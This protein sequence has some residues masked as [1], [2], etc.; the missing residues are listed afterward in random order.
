MK[1]KIDVTRWSILVN[2]IALVLLF[3][4]FA[5]VIIDIRTTNNINVRWYEYLL[6][7][8]SYL[9]F[10]FSGFVLEANERYH[11]DMLKEK[12]EKRERKLNA[13]KA[14]RERRDEIIRQFM[15]RERY[16]RNYV[17]PEV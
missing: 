17:V 5:A 6:L 16:R 7:L 1:R 15:Q 12:Y 14:E 9:V 3:I 10:I 13:E 4:L 11:I 2:G 8:S